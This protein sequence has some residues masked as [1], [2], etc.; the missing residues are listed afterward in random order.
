MNTLATTNFGNI[1]GCDPHKAKK[2][3]FLI[4]DI[5][6]K[7]CSKS[8]NNL[9]CSLSFSVVQNFVQFF[10]SDCKGKFYTFFKVRQ[11]SQKMYLVHI[12]VIERLLFLC[13]EVIDISYKLFLV[14]FKTCQIL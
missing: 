5:M 13:I 9:A 10:F 3:S 4:A 8:M 6:N 12:E 7:K 14:Q 2:T 11:T 1:S